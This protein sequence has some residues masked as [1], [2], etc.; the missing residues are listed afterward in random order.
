VTPERLREIERLFH[1]AREQPPAERHAWLARECADDSGL[2][3]EVESLLA[4]APGGVLDA[5]V[6]ALVADLVQPPGVLP[7][8]R[9]IGGFEVQGLLG[10]GGMGEVYRARDTRLG[11]DVAIKIVPRAFKDDPGRLARFERE[12]RVLAS[13][14]HPHIGAIYGLEEAD[15]VTALVMELV[16]GD[17]LSQRIARGAIPIAEALAIARQIAEAL[18]AAH[19]QG[20]IHRDLKPANIKVRPDGAVKVLDFGLAK[21]L[22]PTSASSAEMMNSPTF[23]P[24][25][26]MMGTIIGTAAYMAPEQARGKAVDRRADI[27]AFGVVV[28]EMLTGRRPFDG[29]D[30]STTLAS[31]L[32]DDVRWQALPANLPA[33]AHRM[34]RRCLEKDPRRR[35]SAIGDARIELEDAMAAPAE[36]AP[37]PTPRRWSGLALSALVLGIAIAL[38][39]LWMGRDRLRSSAALSPPDTRVIRLTDLPGLED[40]P[41]ISPDGKSVAF[42]AGD[43][44]KRQVFVR[45]IAGGAPLQLTRDR[46]DHESPRWSPDSSSVLYFVP[47]VPGTTQGSIWEIPAL[48]GVPRRVVNSVGGADVSPKDGRLAL[49]RLAN[50]RIQLVTAPMDGSRFDVVAEFE[51]V[52]YHLYPRWSPDGRWIAFQQGDS[53]RFDVFVA[54]AAGGK[55]LEPRRN[56]AL[57]ADAQP[58]AGGIE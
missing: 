36:P 26:T 39:F 2:R 48:G 51:P 14:N 21:A 22:D 12:A 7:V 29:D 3:R 44:G 6:G 20:V 33:P 40:S 58:V 31:V 46:V 45:L 13:L 52:T 55:Q 24:P 19:E 43:G 18:E 8:G 23:T 11:R 32:K 10:V 38:V 50:E 25:S 15:D 53:I 42:T 5:P 56:D 47:A 57:S 49:F 9:R 34:L 54:P 41:A 4:Q 30:F 35:L 27:W 1:A 16:D 17:D 37:P 28:Y